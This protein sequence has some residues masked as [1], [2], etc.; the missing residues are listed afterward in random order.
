MKGNLLWDFT[1]KFFMLVNVLSIR[2]CSLNV[3][4]EMG[5][6]GATEFILLSLGLCLL[7]SLPFYHSWLQGKALLRY[8]R[9]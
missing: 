4:D 3:F 8:F 9:M 1:S 2:D 7:L 5:P 6:P